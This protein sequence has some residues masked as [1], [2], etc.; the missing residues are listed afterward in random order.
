VFDT[1]GLIGGN[2]VFEDRETGS[3]SQ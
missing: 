1:A 3:R 2:A